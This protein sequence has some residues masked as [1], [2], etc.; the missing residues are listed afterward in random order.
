MII[1]FNS[2]EWET[3]I[4]INTCEFHKRSPSKIWAGCTCSASYSMARKKGGLLDEK[5]KKIMDNLMTRFDGAWKELGGNG[6]TE[7]CDKC[8]TAL[9]IKGGDA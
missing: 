7:F 2:D 4:E 1:E 3:E 5:G 8:G 9:G 6:T